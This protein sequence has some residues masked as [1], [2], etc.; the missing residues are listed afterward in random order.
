VVPALNLVVVHTVDR[1]LDTPAPPMRNVGRLLWLI[2]KAAG[3]DAG[4]DVSL[5]AAVGDRPKGEELTAR[6]QGKTLS[7]GAR[8][9]EGPFT[10][11]FEP[12]GRLTPL[13][14]NRVLGPPEGTWTVEGEQLCLLR[15]VSRCY[16]PVWADQ[17]VRLFDQYGVMQIDAAIL[18]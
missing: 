17:R 16:V 9:K 13:Q 10:L 6:M 8:S 12:E 2:L 14:W 18:P 7:F 11:R 1:D 15:A 3:Y 4:P 5:A